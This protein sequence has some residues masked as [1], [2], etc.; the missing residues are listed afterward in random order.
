MMLLNFSQLAIAPSKLNEL[1]VTSGYHLP[2]KHHEF[3]TYD[4]SSTHRAMYIAI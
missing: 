4:I 2:C 1:N 3:L